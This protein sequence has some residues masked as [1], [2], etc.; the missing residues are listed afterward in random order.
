[1]ESRQPDLERIQSHL[2]ERFG[3]ALVSVVLYGSR[4]RGDSQDGSDIDL[5]V[6]LRDLPAEW[7]EIFTMEDALSQFGLTL[8]LRLD[9]R[10]VES[11]AVTHAV[12]SATPLMLEIGDANRVLF[13]PHAFFTTE[14]N[15]FA[16]VRQERGIRKLRRGVWRAPSPVSQQVTLEQLLAGVTEENLHPEF[17]T[18]LPTG[19]EV[20]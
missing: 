18:G 14:L 11:N 10:L 5:L 2:Q 6:V 16:H 1:M 15:R 20:L 8:G 4:A 9:V 3:E 19:R 12:T 13:D 7:R 17:E